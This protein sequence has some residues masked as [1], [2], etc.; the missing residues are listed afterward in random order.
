MSL[1]NRRRAIENKSN[2]NENIIYVYD[3]FVSDTTGVRYD[4]IPKYDSIYPDAVA[5]SSI[6]VEEG[7]ITNVRHTGTVINKRLRAY[8]LNGNAKGTPSYSYNYTI[9][10]NIG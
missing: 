7:D 8:D 6:P 10:Q 1:L 5:T 4:D 2:I 9:P 3:D